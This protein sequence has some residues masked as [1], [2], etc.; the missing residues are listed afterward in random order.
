MEPTSQYA[1]EPPRWTMSEH[2]YI[3]KTF[4]TI[5]LGAILY[6]IIRTRLAKRELSQH[7]VQQKRP[8]EYFSDIPSS[9]SRFAS[10]RYCT[11]GD[12]VEADS[13]TSGRTQRR[14]PLEDAEFAAILKV[15]G[16][17]EIAD[18]LLSEACNGIRW[19]DDSVSGDR[20][21]MHH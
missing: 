8:S 13:P 1:S 12:P 14:T 21:N 6:K 15:A 20:D 3:L 19:V 16:D 5:L 2:V 18:F 17:A 9:T 11:T 10:H 4:G 7:P